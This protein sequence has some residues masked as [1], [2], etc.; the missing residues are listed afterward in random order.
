MKVK[1]DPNFRR[2]GQE[3]YTDLSIPYLDAILGD[4]KTVKTIDGE[5]KIKI[6]SGSQPETVL[7][8]KGHGA[9]K[10]G[11]ATNRGNHYVT[12]KV[13][14]PEKLSKR[15]KELFEELKTLQNA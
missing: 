9:P 15:E 8:M 2:E 6:P 7:R 10:L 1:S 3:I 4:E 13:K 5:V 11:D 14:I 12:L